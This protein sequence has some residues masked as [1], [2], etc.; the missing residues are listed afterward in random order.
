MRS[1]LFII[2]SLAIVGAGAWYSLSNSNGAGADTLEE[3][4]VTSVERRDIESRL[5]LTGEVAPAFE[6]EV[7][8]EVGGKIKHLGANVGDWMQRGDV[9]AIIDDSNILIDKSA[10]ETE[11][12]GA[13]L[14]VDKNRGN[15]ERA[16]KLFEEKLISKEVF[17]NL[18]ADYQI[19]ENSLEKARARLRI[20]EDRLSK[21]KIQA[22]ADGT[23]LNVDVSE[24]QVVVAAASVNSGT[25]LMKFA[26]LTRLLINAHVNQVD[27]QK[28]APGQIIDVTVSGL[29]G[30]PIKAAIDFIAPVATVKNNIKGFEVQA[31]IEKGEARLK[32]GMSVR[33]SVPIAQASQAVAIPVSAIFHDAKKNPVV[34]V[35]KGEVAEKRAIE[36]GI[37]DLI[38]AEVRSGLNEGEEIFLTEP[39]SGGAS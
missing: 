30:A 25:V 13:E 17:D 9:L 10:A 21:T 15:Y 18:R 4:D 14:A 33:M 39:P 20:V 26:D 22:P 2:F 35:R 19:A 29:E 23:V 24:G 36:L 32:P 37:T 7:K 12:E 31:V 34:Y 3:L 16:R 5:L 6:V 1:I 27:A 38:F 11:I 8:A 28:L